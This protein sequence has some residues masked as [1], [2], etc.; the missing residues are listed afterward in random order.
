MSHRQ[1]TRRRI[2]SSYGKNREGDVEKVSTDQGKSHDETALQVIEAAVDL[3]MQA[4]YELRSGQ[5][6]VPEHALDRLRQ[7]LWRASDHRQP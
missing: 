3:I 5:Y 6:R 7:A 1:L 4:T 2:V